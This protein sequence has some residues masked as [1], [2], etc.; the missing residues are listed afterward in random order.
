RQW[1]HG[2]LTAQPWTGD[3]SVDGTFVQAQGQFLRLV[4][5][6]AR[7]RPETIWSWPGQPATSVRLTHEV[8][9]A[10]PVQEYGHRVKTGLRQPLTHSYVTPPTVPGLRFAE[11]ELVVGHA[12][13]LC[14]YEST[15]SPTSPYA[16][17]RGPRVTR[18]TRRR[19]PASGRCRHPAPPPCQTYPAARSARP[20]HSSRPA[21]GKPT[22]A[23]G[24]GCRGASAARRGRGTGRPA[25]A[26][27]RRCRRPRGHP[28]WRSSRT[29]PAPRRRTLP[30][31]PAARTPAGW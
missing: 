21:A 10:H 19:R 9:P 4:P 2:L 25:G 30:R 18:R 8:D 5:A 20:P 12:N 28:A 7:Q 22:R 16:A 29:T 11:F 31:G 14:A 24:Q 13:V 3:D 15:F 27:S 1:Q 26:L 6:S 23:G 17:W